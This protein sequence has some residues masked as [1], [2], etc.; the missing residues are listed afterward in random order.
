MNSEYK[1]IFLFSY[2]CMQN[3]G[4]KRTFAAMA[5]PPSTVNQKRPFI[6]SLKAKCC[7]RSRDRSAPKC[8]FEQMLRKSDLLHSEKTVDAPTICHL[9]NSPCSV[10]LTVRTR[11]ASNSC[12][13]N[14]RHVSLRRKTYLV[15][16]VGNGGACPHMRMFC[17]RSRCCAVQAF[18]W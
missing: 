16:N 9:L 17:R 1:K 2:A 14:I 10:A 18:D 4:G 11:A 8:T 7:T 5:Q 12:S 13:E 6:E 3:S 15:R